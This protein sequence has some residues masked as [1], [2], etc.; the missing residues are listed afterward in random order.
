M[1]LAVFE[2]GYLNRIYPGVSV[3]GVELGG[4]NRAEA[5]ERLSRQLLFLQQETVTFR[6]GGQVWAATPGQ[7]GMSVRI[8]DAVDRAF[9]VGHSGRLVPDLYEQ[10][11]AFFD[12]V[13]IAPV[14]VLD[15]VM[16]EEMV[17]G[18]A[19]VVNVE[20]ND[21]SLSVIGSVLTVA[22]GNQG[23]T[24]D[25]HATVD[26]LLEPLTKFSEAEVP[27]VID[28]FT[29]MVVDADEERVIGQ[30]ILDAPLVLKV[31]Y[32]RES[33]GPPWVVDQQALADMLTLLPVKDGG[34]AMEYKV[35]LDQQ[36]LRNFLE[37]AS[38]QLAV[39]PENARFGFDEDVGAMKLVRAAVVGRALDVEGTLVLVNTALEDGEH[40]IY[41]RFESVAPDIDD[42]TRAEELG[43]TGLVSEATTFF[44][45]SG[46]ARLQNIRAG[47]ET[48]HG[49][50]VPP[51]SEF[52][53]NAN[54]GSV[55]LDTG[56]AEAW[57]IFGGRTIQGVGGGI[58][59]VSTT[60]FRSAF[61]AGYPIIERN[62]HAY[63]VGYYEQGPDSPGPGLDATVF[64]PVA[65]FRFLNDREA[66]LL[67]ETEFDES[68]SSL[69]FRFYS[70]N[71]GRTVTVGEAEVSD[72]EEAKET[73]YEE[74]LE[75]ESGVLKQVDWENEG[76]KVAVPRVVERGDYVMFEDV[77]Q[78]TY[79]PWG[80][81]FQFGPGTELPEGAEVVWAV[82]VGEG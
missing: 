54:L 49:V 9:E 3:W 27:L 77:V 39:A 51:E 58:C 14:I 80:S 78:T 26:K 20:P 52:S 13:Y 57:I 45:G 23:R 16:A 73:V 29:P 61:F 25:V 32:P 17:K 63:R 55:S 36:R 71:D 82:D 28:E 12:G 70:A 79:Q 56:F 44:R 2:M 5:T 65:D 4:K 18:I 64:S 34:D 75:L 8:R 74:N 41:L 37:Y 38:G 46:E 33:D 35:G 48:M 30:R 66:W 21:A 53:F 22:E 50:M 42:E 68:E 59:Q 72:V 6:D 15:M 76:A 81:V 11:W 7:V 24:V 31:E 62:P 1:G 67:I 19:G 47:A 69:T 40:N 10:W 43:I 60:A